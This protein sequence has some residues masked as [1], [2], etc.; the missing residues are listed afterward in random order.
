MSADHTPMHVPLTLGA[1]ASL[2]GGTVEGDPEMALEGVAPVEGAGPSELAFLATKRYA[3][4]LPARMAMV[5]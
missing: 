1:V 4:S 5:P 2:V 3:R